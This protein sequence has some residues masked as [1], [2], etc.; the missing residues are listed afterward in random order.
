MDLITLA[1]AK[2][3]ALNVASGF[4]SVSVDDKTSTI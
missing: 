2:K 3:F 4:S 1:M